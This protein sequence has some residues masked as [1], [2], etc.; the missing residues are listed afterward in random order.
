MDRKIRG[1]IISRLISRM[2]RTV[3]YIYNE[4]KPVVSY[5]EEGEVEVK[6]YYTGEIARDK[7]LSA[8]LYSYSHI[9]HAIADILVDGS[10]H[11]KERMFR[12]IKYVLSKIEEEEER[13]K[14]SLLDGEMIQLLELRLFEI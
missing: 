4:E 2:L 14:S 7:Y 12:I 11:D 5:V 8:V 9:F 13:D 10:D 3:E 1:D 6:E